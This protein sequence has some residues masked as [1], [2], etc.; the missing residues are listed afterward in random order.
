MTDPHPANLVAFDHPDGLALTALAEQLLDQAGKVA[1][2]VG[3]TQQANAFAV[4][5]QGLTRVVEA[6]G[7]TYAE[8]LAG[9][10]SAVGWALSN[11]DDLPTRLAILNVFSQ[12]VWDSAVRGDAAE[13]AFAAEPVGRA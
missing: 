7:F 1:G 6:K 2:M 12:T 5:L 3:N 4:A 9:L 13:Q 11:E 10:A 8:A